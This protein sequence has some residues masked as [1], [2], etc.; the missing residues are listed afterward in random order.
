MIKRYKELLS[1]IDYWTIPFKCGGNLYINYSE[2][3]L[4]N[5]IK[6]GKYRKYL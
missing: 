3:F 4:I 5:G 2:L 1:F 6:L